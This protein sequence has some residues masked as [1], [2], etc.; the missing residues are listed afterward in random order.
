MTVVKSGTEVTI[1]GLCG[2]Q[3]LLRPLRVRFAKVLDYP[4]YGP[5]VVWVSVYELDSLGAAVRRRELLVIRDA[6]EAACAP[7][8]STQLSKEACHA[9]SR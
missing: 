3:F 9:I 2:C 4:T 7:S 5:A 6:F 8:Q 1:D